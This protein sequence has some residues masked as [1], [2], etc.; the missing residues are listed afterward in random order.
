MGHFTYIHPKLEV[1]LCYSKCLDFNISKYSFYINFLKN[2]SKGIRSVVRFVT[3]C[4]I[5]IKC[6]P[7]TYPERSDNI[8][9]SFF[10]RQ[11]CGVVCIFKFHSQ[12]TNLRP[13]YVLL[14]VS[15]KG[16]GC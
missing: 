4:R 1:Y 13:E 14:C 16:I 15:R 5:P 7:Q 2:T 12:R 11:G 9:S 10:N 8:A 6:L 3:V